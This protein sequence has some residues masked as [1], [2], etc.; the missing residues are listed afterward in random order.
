MTFYNV[1]SGILFLAAC[2]TFLV[3][4]GTANMWIAATLVVTILNESVL[5][6]ELIERLK[7][8]IPYKLSMKLVDFLGFATLVWALLIVTPRNN[9]LEVDVSQSLLG[10][11]N[12]RW[13]WSLLTIYWG[14][15]LWWNQLAKQLGSGAWENWFERWMK[16]MWTFPLFVG[17]LTWRHTTFSSL[18]AWAGF[19][20]T[21]VVAVYLP[22][23]LLGQKRVE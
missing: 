1:I 10:A 21:A 4:L 17:I 6:S 19:V 15:T 2:Q 13:F 16:F 9:A 8:P 18:P 14:L 23:K 5:T 7:N 12:P 3:T 22:M 20:T 11:G